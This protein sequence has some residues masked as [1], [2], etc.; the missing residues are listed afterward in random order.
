MTEWPP[1]TTPEPAQEESQSV[2][3]T[4][5]ADETQPVVEAP[6]LAEWPT[7]QDIEPVVEAAV[8]AAVEQVV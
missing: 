7:S 4:Q 3:V 8:D 1:T 2:A 5:T 6:K